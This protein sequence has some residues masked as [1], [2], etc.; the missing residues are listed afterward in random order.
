[1]SFLKS[2]EINTAGTYTQ[3]GQYAINTSTNYLL[4]LYGTIG[5]LR[6]AEDDRKTKLF[7][8]AVSED[9]LLAAKILFHSRDIREGIGER[10]T[11]RVL[12]KHAADRYPEMVIPNI[13]LIGYYGRFD[14]MY[15]LIG[16]KCEAEMWKAMGAQLEKD[17]ANM[18][19]GKP[20]SLLAKWIKTPDASSEKT[21][22]LGILTSQK[23]GYLNVAAFKKDLKPLRKYL[24]IVEIDVSANSFETI[25]YDQVPSN[26]MMKYRNLFLKKDEARF[27]QYLEDVKSGNKKINSGT[28]YPYDFILKIF[29]A[30]YDETL[31]LQWKNLPNYVEDGSNVLVM[32]DTSGSMTCCNRMPIASALGLAIYFAERAKGVFHN[33]FMTFSMRPSLQTIAGANLR[34]K[35]FNMEDAHW[36]MDTNIMAAMRVILKAAKDS[37]ATQEEIPKALVIISDMEFNY[38]AKD[39]LFYDVCKAE[40]EAAGYKL[41]NII[42]WN[43]NS[44]NDIFHATCDTPGVQLL[45]GHSV[46]SFKQLLTCIDKTPVEAMMEVLLSER[47]EPI[48]VVE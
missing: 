44:M 42:F 45:S 41:P 7:D 36:D 27:N 10:E 38:C 6:K 5:A 31:E 9:K 25:A 35:V 34:D 17:L 46:S 18:K 3:N 15:C 2:L 33:K 23:L 48:T 8:R 4:D 13:P 1:M 28:L 47:Y 11:F 21:R 19:A 32:A 37:N 40:Y 29:R 12:L 14:D 30:E 22:A 20:V 16:T 24:K 43:V 26:A 39:T